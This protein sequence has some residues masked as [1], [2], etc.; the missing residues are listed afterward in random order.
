MRQSYNS[1]G[2]EAIRTGRA[3]TTSICIVPTY[4]LGKG[5]LRAVAALSVTRLSGRLPAVADLAHSV[6]CS[7][8]G[9]RAS[10]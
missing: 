10:G 2:R 5:V 9:R 3:P 1:T 6:S 8:H 7:Q 4:G